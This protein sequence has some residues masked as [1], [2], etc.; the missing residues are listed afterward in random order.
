MDINTDVSP[1]QFAKFAS[2]AKSKGKSVSAYLRE[3]I[4]HIGDQAESGVNAERIQKKEYN[5]DDFI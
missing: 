3:V 5:K 1:T 2:V 4:K